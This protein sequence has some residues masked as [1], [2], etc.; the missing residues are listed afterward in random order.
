MRFPPWRSG[1]FFP[2]AL[3]AIGCGKAP[4]KQGALAIPTSGNVRVVSRKVAQTPSRLQWKWSVIGERNWRSAQVKDATASLT[5]TYPLND[6]TQSGGCNIWECDLTAERGQWTLT[7]HG[8]DGTT[9]TGTGA[10]PANAG[11]DPRKAV[12]IREEADRL[13]SLPADLTLA[14]VD[15]KTVAFH[16]DR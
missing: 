7:L 3:L 5:K 9:A 14:T 11:A 1:I 8:S 10:L 16:I 15:G 12:Q 13:T 2:M 6:A 4:R